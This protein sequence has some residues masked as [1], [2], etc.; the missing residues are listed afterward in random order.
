MAMR[1]VH[2]PLV[3]LIIFS[4]ACNSV[5]NTDEYVQSIELM[6]QSKDSQFYNNPILSPENLSQFNGLK[7]FD[8]SKKYCV[9]AKITPIDRQLTV[10]RTNT[11]RSPEYYTVCKLQFEIDGHHGE[12]I[13]YSID[14]IHPNSLFIPFKDLTNNKTS[15]GAGR[16]I[17]CEMESG[18]NTLTLDFNQSYNPYCHYNHSYSCPIVPE[19]NHLKFDILAGEKMLYENA[20]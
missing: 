4:T 3:V 18:K 1:F 7:Y 19:S 16:Y 11:E 20:H 6:R 10:F 5:K 8:V 9:E 17:D 2:I 12:L 13:A 14:S 15:Y